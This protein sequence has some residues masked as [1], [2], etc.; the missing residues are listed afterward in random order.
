MS[1]YV[2]GA[3]DPASHTIQTF[4][5]QGQFDVAVTN[6]RYTPVRQD[7]SDFMMQKF[8]G[9]TLLDGAP[10]NVWFDGVWFEGQ[11]ELLQPHWGRDVPQPPASI[12]ALP[13]VPMPGAVAAGY[14][15]YKEGGGSILDG[16][17]T[18]AIVAAG[19]ALAYAVFRKS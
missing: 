8:E 11:Q 19:L 18:P 15:A 3:R 14:R 12:I 5:D 7:G 2:V 17:P 13:I 10:L 16:I 1:Q 4:A 6:Y 9:G